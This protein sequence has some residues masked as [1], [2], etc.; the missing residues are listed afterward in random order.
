MIQVSLWFS[1]GLRRHIQVT[2]AVLHSFPGNFILAHT[3]AIWLAS[4][5]HHA[6]L[7]HRTEHLLLLLLLKSRLRLSYMLESGAQRQHDTTHLCVIRISSD[8]LRFAFSPLCVEH[9]PKQAPPLV[10]KAA[11]GAFPRQI[12]SG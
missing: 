12:R 1:Q 4:H 7:A 8:I 9:V 3:H 6:A 10:Q 11:L 5:G 2:I